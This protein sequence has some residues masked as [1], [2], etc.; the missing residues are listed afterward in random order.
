MLYSLFG[1]LWIK[2]NVERAKEK[3]YPSLFNLSPLPFPKFMF[4]ALP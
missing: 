2:E 3:G 1:G 4:L